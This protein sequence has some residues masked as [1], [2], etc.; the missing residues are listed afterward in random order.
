MRRATDSP[1]L[2]HQTETQHIHQHTR[3]FPDTVWWHQEPLSS[4]TGDY[5]PR[6]QISEARGRQSRLQY[7]LYEDYLGGK[8]AGQG[9]GRQRL[10]RDSQDITE[11]LE[12]KI[13]LS[14]KNKVCARNCEGMRRTGWWRGQGEEGVS[15]VLNILCSVCFALCVV[16]VL[17]SHTP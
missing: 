9:D 10:Y 8:A 5:Y 17:F 13:P 11:G 4:P 1:K 15:A 12:K 14:H 7:H 2:R 3:L 6:S 16:L